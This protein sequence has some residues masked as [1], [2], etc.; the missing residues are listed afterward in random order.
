MTKRI[1]RQDYD[2]DFDAPE[3][4]EDVNKRERMERR[5]KNAP[6]NSA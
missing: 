1:K 5:A 6:R 4:I 2:S 3:E